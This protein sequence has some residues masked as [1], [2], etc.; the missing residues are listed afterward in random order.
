[1]RDEQLRRQEADAQ[2]DGKLTCMEATCTRAEARC[3][4]MTA[5][6][7][8][9]LMLLIEAAKKVSSQYLLWEEQC[10][11]DCLHSGLELP[12]NAVLGPR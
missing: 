12:R 4:S 9:A 11:D 2:T 5:R 1:M 10:I 8:A 3:M 6:L 7:D